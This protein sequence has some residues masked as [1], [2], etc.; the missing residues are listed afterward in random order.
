[1]GLV[2]SKLSGAKGYL[3]YGRGLDSD[4]FTFLTTAGITNIVQ[5]KAINELVIDLKGYGIWTKQKALY[6]FVGGTAVAHKFNLKNPA[7]TN[8]AYRLTFSAGW[9]HS[10]TGALPNGSAYAETY[11][12][13]STT[14]TNY[15]THLSYYSRTNLLETTNF[16]IGSYNGSG[17]NL[18]CLVLPRNTGNATSI[19]Y[20]QF[21]ATNY[22]LATGQTSTTGFWMSNRTSNVGSTHKLWRN[23]VSIAAASTTGGS[24]LAN[25]LWISAINNSLGGSPPAYYSRKECAFASIG[26][27]LT[28]AEA[29]NFYTAV[30]KFQTTLGRQV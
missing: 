13:P 7:D 22:A 5:Q 25:T 2:L 26:D 21:T 6:P 15:N 8:G 10:S 18:F 9:T 17:G 23:G 28:D 16:E 29:A 14:L 12:V 11:L 1:M 20:D 24:F 19:Q 27:G 4:A 3:N 30:Q